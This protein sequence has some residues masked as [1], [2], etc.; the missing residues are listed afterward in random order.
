MNFEEILLRM[1]YAIE[2]AD[3][4]SYLELKELAMEIIIERNYIIL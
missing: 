1:F 4:E 2:T 3:F